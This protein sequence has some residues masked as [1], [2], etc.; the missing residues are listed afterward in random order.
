MTKYNIT[1]KQSEEK[2][3]EREVS[4]LIGEF[5]TGS[6]G[7]YLADYAGSNEYICDAIAQIA[8][9]HTSIYYYEMLDFIKENPEALAEVI[10][11]GLYDPSHNYSLWDHARAAEYLVIEKDIY[12][13]LVDSLIVAN[14][15][16]IKFDL[17]I[18]TIPEEL[19]TNL[20]E[21][22]ADATNCDRMSEISDKINEYLEE[23]TDE[24]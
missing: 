23:F 22:C 19:Y 10:D 11:E 4:E 17:R 16:Y 1:N 14:L 21:W 8:D 2:A 6:Y 20:I 18:S 9:N 13:N 7:E 3:K 12:S 24:V 5:D 15:A